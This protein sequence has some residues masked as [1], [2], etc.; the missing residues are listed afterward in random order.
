MDMQMPEM[1]GLEATRVIL[2]RAAP[3]ARPRIVAMTANVSDEDR[4]EA[5]AAGMDGYITK[6]IRVPDLVG[7]LLDA[8][9]AV[10]GHVGRVR[11]Y[12]I[13]CP[14]LEIWKRARLRRR[15]RS[16]NVERETPK[17]AI[18]LQRSDGRWSS[19]RTP[20]GCSRTTDRMHPTGWRGTDP[21]RR[22]LASGSPAAIAFAPTATP[23][24]N[25]SSVP[26]ATAARPLLSTS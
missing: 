1:D 12:L 5:D 13:F 3:E 20:P 9:D 6:P 25:P 15:S 21:L 7:A 18:R 8:G 14:R 4:R 10:S 26:L 24:R 22:T 2:L 17:G 11:L 19:R 16:E 23:Q